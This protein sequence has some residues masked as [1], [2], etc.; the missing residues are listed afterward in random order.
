M[1]GHISAV[2]QLCAY[3]QVWINIITYSTYSR[4]ET[5]TGQDYNYSCSIHL[6]LY[7]G[8]VFTIF[9]KFIMKNGGDINARL[10]F[11]LSSLTFY[12]FTSGQAVSYSSTES[13]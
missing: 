11:I 4:R 13:V 1:H 10:H 5:K 12:I 6:F 3:M 8:V 2:Y 7:L 9:S